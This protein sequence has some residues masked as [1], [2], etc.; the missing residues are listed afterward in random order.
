MISQQ[1]VPL[2]LRRMFDHLDV[3]IE[4]SFQLK[5]VQ[6]KEAMVKCQQCGK[7]FRCDYDTESRYFRCPNRDLLDDLEDA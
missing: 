7:F 5:P 3:S 4:H 1:V 6:M 2:P